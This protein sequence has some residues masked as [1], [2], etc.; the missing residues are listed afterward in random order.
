M[1][2]SADM[3]G[4]EMAANIYTDDKEIVIELPEMIDYLLTIN[5]ETMDSDIQNLVEMGMLDQET[6]DE[7]VALNEGTD[8]DAISEEAYEKFQK[9][10]MDTLK[11]F[12]NA[13]E[14]KKGDSKELT[15][16]GKNVNC[17]GYVL[18][19]TSEDT[20]D[21]VENLKVVYQ[22]NEECLKSISSLYESSNLD[23]L[24][25][26]DS[27]YEKFDEAVEELRDMEDKTAEIEFYLYS[28]KVAQIYFE[29]N[30]DAYIEWNI[31]GGNFPLENTSFTYEDEFGDR[32]VIERRGSCEDDKYQA[33]YEAVN[34]YDEPVAFEIQYKKNKGDFSLEILE[35]GD[36]FILIDGNIDKSDDNTVDVD[37]DTLEMD[38]ESV[39]SGK[40]SIANI[41]DDIKRP[42][43]EER[44]MLL[45]SEDEWTQVVMDIVESF[46]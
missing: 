42:T 7:L 32:F 35:D 17:K 19:I 1:H 22:D 10:L 9:E 5:R 21:F 26:L 14:M 18:V 40:I 36:S 11:N 46:Y 2:I 30:D 41:C 29:G 6:V 12:Y 4:V 45:L 38:G 43:G 28:G 13:C 15:V 37:I 34:E 24:S 3:M 39:L 20:A 8:E 31:E 25:D 16:N 23:S 44:E 33:R 27:L